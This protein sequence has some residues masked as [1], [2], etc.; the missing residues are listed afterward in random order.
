MEFLS[1]IGFKSIGDV[2]SNTTNDLQRMFEKP[3]QIQSSQINS[4]QISNQTTIRPKPLFNNSNLKR[5]QSKSPLTSESDKSKLKILKME[6]KPNGVEIQL[7]K[8]LP[9]VGFL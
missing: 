3:A 7:P 6:L 4:T 5:K 8:P 1:R 9:R 2:I